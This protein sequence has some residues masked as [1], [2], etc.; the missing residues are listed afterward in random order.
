MAFLVHHL[1]RET[2]ARSADKTALIAGDDRRS[3]AAL[4]R[5]SDTL[6]HALRRQGVARG[7]RVAL[8]AENTIDTVVAL[9]GVLKAGAAVVPLNP[10]T[11]R[12]KLAFV[13]NDCGVR[14]VI[15]P[16]ACAEEVRP[17]VADAP[18]VRATLWLG[19][20]LEDGGPIDE[21]R[22]IDA[23]LAAIIY[24]SGSTGRPKGVMLTHRNIVNTS[25]SISCYLGHTADDVVLCV[26]PLSFDYG[27][28]QVF[29]AVRVGFSLVLERSFVFPFVVLKTMAK[30]GVTSL[31]GV[32]TIF[33][34]L[35][36]LDSFHAGT[37]PTLRRMTN[38][39]AALPPA[40]IR[41]LR[42]LFPQARLF[43]MYGL[44]ES[45]RVAY[46]DP[47]RL[48]DKIGSVG[49]AMPNC[50]AYVVDDD[51]NRAAPGV[52]GELVVRGANVMPGY[53]GRPEETAKRLRDGVLRTGDLFTADEEGFLY[54]VG[55]KDDVF[56][57]R[58][59][60]VS[61]KEIEN[62]LYELPDVAEAAVIGVPDEIDGTAI[63][64]HVVPRSGSTLDEAQVRRHCRARLESRL[65]PKFIAFC[66]ALPKTDTGKIRRAALAESA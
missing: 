11:K 42:T 41:R 62:V 22:M 21:P 31:P 50:E 18:S 56:K 6:A 45:T 58:G 3:F 1:L 39:A 43:S 47:D 8:L 19:E 64:A 48:D 4:D 29:M 51:G 59:E 46:L 63:K 7:D 65:V 33:A 34:M 5:D 28:F 52:V 13:L 61:P 54:F 14:A 36:Q 2:A 37:V 24:T 35:L 60:K 38:T 27:L 17:A 40:H 44:T 49:K 26:P 30:H 66:T 15:A 9:Y 20:E 32:P 12:D 25:W 10:T 55:R 53:W 16:P 57:C 23:D